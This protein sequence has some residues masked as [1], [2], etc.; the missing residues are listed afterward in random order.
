MLR[1]VRADEAVSRDELAGENEPLRRALDKLTLKRTT[2]E[3]LYIF[4]AD[5][6]ELLYRVLR[7]TVFTQDQL[8]HWIS[9]LKADHPWWNRSVKIEVWMAQARIFIDESIAALS[10]PRW[11]RA[12]IAMLDHTA[13]AMGMERYQRTVVRWALV[14]LLTTPAHAP[15]ASATG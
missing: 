8:D 6:S 12:R 15:S 9:A 13:S 2:G 7:G 3:D 14:H 10:E 1:L 11:L 4:N 5:E